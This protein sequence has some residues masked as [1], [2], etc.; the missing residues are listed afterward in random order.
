MSFFNQK[1]FDHTLVERGYHCLE[2]QSLMNQ[3]RMVYSL[4]FSD[5]IKKCIFAMATSSLHVRIP[6]KT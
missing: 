3:P 2:W 5:Y 6:S 1:S 4:I